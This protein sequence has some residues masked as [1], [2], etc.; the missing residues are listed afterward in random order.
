MKHHDIRMRGFATRHDVDEALALLEQRINALPSEVIS[1]AGGLDR[2]LAEDMVAAADVP[3]FDRSAVDGY[4][5]RARDTF[6]ASDYNPIPLALRGEIFP[7]RALDITLGGNGPS[8]FVVSGSNMS[9]K[10]TWLRA[11]GVGVV[12]AQAGAPVRARS[13]R[14][15]PLH[16]GASMRVADSLIDGRSRFMAEITRL[17][18]VVDLAR[19]HQGRA[20]FLLDELLGGTNSHDRRHGA[21]GLLAGLTGLGAIGL[22]TTHDLALGALADR[23]PARAENVH[24]EDAFDGTELAFD[25]R[26]RPGIVR[27]TNAIALM[28]SVG[29]DV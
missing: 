19:A 21:E 7:G 9:G 28:K 22:V 3:H 5:V 26:L 12:L 2:V 20:L 10:S 24:F 17:K 11:V 15:S 25:Y 8:L 29:L 27:T 18:Q 13:F 16:V 14:L 6:G 4:G 23:L 1:L